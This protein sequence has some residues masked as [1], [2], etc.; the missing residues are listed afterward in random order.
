MLSEKKFLVYFQG[1]LSNDSRF[2]CDFVLALRILRRSKYRSHNIGHTFM[3]FHLRH[4]SAEENGIRT[5]DTCAGVLD[6]C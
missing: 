3:H 2:E 6:F 1:S 5:G 4:Y